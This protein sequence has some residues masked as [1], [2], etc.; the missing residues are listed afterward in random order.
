MES[1]NIED[2][3]H[4]PWNNK[5]WTGDYTLPSNPYQIPPP[6]NPYMEPQTT[7]IP[8]P[9]TITNMHWVFPKKEKSMN[10]AELE[11]LEGK[12]VL[13]F[14]SQKLLPALEDLFGNDDEDLNSLKEEYKA[15]RSTFRRIHN[16]L[17]SDE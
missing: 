17:N 9:F 16:E 4:T 5:W 2:F 7:A 3:A 1:N 12:V 13:E 10:K 8:D 6:S 15:M 11:A 14:V